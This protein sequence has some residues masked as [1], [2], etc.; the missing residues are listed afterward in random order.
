M[1]ELIFSCVSDFPYYI[2]VYCSKNY[3]LEI[4]LRSLYLPRGVALTLRITSVH[5][6]CR[7]DFVANATRQFQN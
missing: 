3:I 7:I 2:G 4:N 1:A 6:I 5:A